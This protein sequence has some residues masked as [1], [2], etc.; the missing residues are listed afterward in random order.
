MALQIGMLL[1]PQLTQLDFTGPQEVLARIPD[2]KVHMVAKSRDPVVAESGL[3]LVPST[4]FAE[5]PRVDL[6]FV[7]GGFGQI[8]ACQDTATIDWLR[9]VA[10]HARWITSACT[11]ALL[12]GCAGLLHGYRATTHWAFHDLLAICGA[13]PVDERVVIDRNRIT[14]GGV[15]AGIDFG[16]TIA[17]EIAGRDVAEAI[18]LELEYN[19]APPFRA[20]HPS[21]A[22]P[23]LVAR[24]RKRTAGRYAERK[25]LLE[26]LTRPPLAT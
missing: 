22:R 14:S 9:Q 5:L 17:A 8:Q 26:R 15:T 16:L 6:L 12:L 10:P 20:G 4:T 21:V 11:G 24:A 19:P 7:P 2:T 25:A 18:Q 1:F 23:E 13:T 3:V